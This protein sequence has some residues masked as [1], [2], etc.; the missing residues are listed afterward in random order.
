MTGEGFAA[1][2]VL[3]AVEVRRG[4]SWRQWSA[5][6]LLS[7]SLFHA[8]MA[9]PR[10]AGWFVVLSLV[11]LLRL[12]RAATV[13]RAFYGGLLVGI[14]VMAPQL[15]FLWKIFGPFAAVLWFL[16]GIWFAIFV[17]AGKLVER[18]FGR[19]WGV[20]IAPFL[21]LGLEFIRC[22]VWPLKFAWLTPGFALPAEWWAGSFHHLGIYG[23]GALLVYAAAWVADTSRGAIK[24]VLPAILPAGLMAL[25][26]AKAPAD[27]GRSI[28]VAGVQWED[29][30]PEQVI[31]GLDEALAQA[32]DAD[33]LVLSEY[34]YQ[35]EPPPEL[36]EWCRQHRK[37]VLV[38]GVDRHTGEHTEERVY[39]TAFLVGPQGDIVL[40]Q[41]KSVPIQFMADGLPARRQRLWDSPAGRV[42]FAICYDMNYVRVMDRL[43]AR[44]AGLLVVPA[45]DV[46]GWGEHA[47][48]LSAQLAAVRAAEYGVPLFRLASSGFSRIARPDGTVAKEAGVPGQGAIIHDRIALPGKGRRPLD[49]WLAWP[50][51]ALTGGLV[52]FLAFEEFR[53]IRAGRPPVEVQ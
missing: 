32:P 38:G 19:D 35:T 7:V 29:P 33:L 34:T 36:L 51:V 21:W 45:M 8:A 5:E 22:E 2:D 31:G 42:G 25:P 11:F 6:I 43:I 4:S 3:D 27:S 20:A 14:G 46:I 1:A 44:D 18:R 39:N 15:L 41:V 49:R 28:T 10:V 48:R 30:L 37:H 12:R 26:S 13:R 24:W 16:L 52:F 47:H 40:R 53:R 9:V 50:C 23:T 17:A